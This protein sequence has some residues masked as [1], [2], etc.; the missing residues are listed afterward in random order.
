ME[1][2]VVATRETV[3]V[4]GSGTRGAVV[5]AADAVTRGIHEETS[6]TSAGAVVL[7]SSVRLASE[8][9]GV[10]G[11]RAGL[12]GVVAVDGRAVARSTHGKAAVAETTAVG[13]QSREVLAGLTS[14]GER[15]LTGVAGV[16]ADYAR[17]CRVHCVSRVADTG[18]VSSQRSVVLATGAACG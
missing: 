9:V 4:V 3:V 16:V 18:S 8:T 11:S 2:G 17:A 6:V 12:A 7:A 5:V 15:V 14:G 1:G 13:L 10:K